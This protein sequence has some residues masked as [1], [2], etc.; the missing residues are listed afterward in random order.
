[1]PFSQECCG[2]LLRWFIKVGEGIRVNILC[3]ESW[4]FYMISVFFYLDN[5]FNQL[6]LSFSVTNFK[7]YTSVKMKMSFAQTWLHK[8]NSSRPDPEWR[9]KIDLNFYFHTSLWCLRRFYEGLKGLDKTF[10]GTKK[11]C[12]NKNLIFT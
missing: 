10:W 2:Q 11:K 8:L 7:N 12:E 6:W 5:V 9:E 4:K 3:Y 1:M